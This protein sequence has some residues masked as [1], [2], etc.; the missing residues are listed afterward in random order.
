MILV[1]R[2]RGQ[3]DQS[4]VLCN[5]ARMLKNVFQILLVF[6]ERYVLTCRTSGQASVIGAEE[7]GLGMNMSCVTIHDGVLVVP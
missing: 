3:E 7:N 2:R 1:D 6:V 4:G 5:D